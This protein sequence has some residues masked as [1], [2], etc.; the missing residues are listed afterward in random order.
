[1]TFKEALLSDI[2]TARRDARRKRRESLPS[3]EWWTEIRDTEIARLLSEAAEAL[4]EAGIGGGRQNK[5]GGSGIVLVAGPPER[6]DDLTFTY[7][8]GKIQVTSSEDG[9]NE[10]WDD[11][12]HVTPETIAAKV[13]DFV[14]LVAAHSLD[15]P[16][17]PLSPY[18]SHGL[19]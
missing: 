16:P 5:N 6:S 9:I 13:R 14:K 7:V 17:L 18:E 4:A 8:T 1:M 19:R 12:R 15:H 3:D 2:E 10:I 11:R